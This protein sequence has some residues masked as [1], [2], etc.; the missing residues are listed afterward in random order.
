MAKILK[1]PLISS[2]VVTLGKPESIIAASLEEPA[3]PLIAETKLEEA[4]SAAYQEGYLSGKEAGEQLVQEEIR[5]LKQQLET[6]L[7]AIPKAIA[8]NRL[9][10]YPE[11]ADIILLITQ[12]YFIEK[13]SD[14]SA[15]E[16]QINHILSQLNEQH[17]VELHLH[18]QDVSILQKGMIQLESMHLNGLKIISDNTLALGGCV[19]KTNHGSFDAS[20]EKQIDKLKSFLLQLKQ[21]GPHASMD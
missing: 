2:D 9:D 7:M 18:P 14:Q 21:R 5:S 12:H 13:S 19:V 4:R 3:P 17:S 11:I 16:H 6:T 1:N 15:L 10:L 8:Q 20:I